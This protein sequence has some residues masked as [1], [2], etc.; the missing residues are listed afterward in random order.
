MQNLTS[1]LYIRVCVCNAQLKHDNAQVFMS[2]PA[3]FDGTV[4]E[5]SGDTIMD[6]GGVQNMYI[7]KNV[8][9]T[10]SKQSLQLELAAN[11]QVSD[12]AGPLRMY[13]LRVLDT[14]TTDPRRILRERRDDDPVS[15]FV[16]DGDDPT[17]VAGW[18]I[19]TLDLGV[20]VADRI[21]HARFEEQKPNWV[22]PGAYK[23][24]LPEHI[25]RTHILFNR[26]LVTTEILQLLVFPALGLQWWLR[27]RHSPAVQAV[28]QSLLEYCHMAQIAR[29]SASHANMC[30]LHGPNCAR[31]PTATLLAQLCL[32]CPQ[33]KLRNPERYRVG[34]CTPDLFDTV[35]A[36]TAPFTTE[37]CFTAY[38][39]RM[40]EGCNMMHSGVSM[41]RNGRLLEAYALTTVKTI[42][43]CMTEAKRKLPSSTHTHTFPHEHQFAMQCR[44]KSV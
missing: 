8:N 44:T 30:G 41:N 2:D 13:S 18:I 10:M 11:L 25:L 24:V 7:P 28:Y 19:T 1:P 20:T 31:C 40:A 3:A 27:N 36:S 23:E 14:E 16:V 26:G 34:F 32:T 35:A 5:S 17:S 12:D 6:L 39:Q 38:A 22:D 29:H 21:A 33:A 15:S 4:P 42:L 37:R 9:P 43:A